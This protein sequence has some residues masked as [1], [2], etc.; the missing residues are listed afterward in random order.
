M[1]YERIPDSERRK[2]SMEKKTS[3]E[4]VVC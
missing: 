2:E 1:N 3:A 4:K